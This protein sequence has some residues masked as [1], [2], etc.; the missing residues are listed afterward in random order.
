VLEEHSGGSCQIGRPSCGSSFSSSCNEESEMPRPD[1]LGNGTR[2]CK[3]R[4]RSFEVVSARDRDGDRSL[5]VMISKSLT[6]SSASRSRPASLLLAV[7]P[8][9]ADQ[10]AAVGDHGFELGGHQLPKSHG[11]RWDPARTAACARGSSTSLT[12]G[13]RRGGPSS[14]AR[15]TADVDARRLGALRPLLR[16]SDHC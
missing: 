2:C 13:R 1:G 15:S 16:Y 4:S 12:G 11:Y 14:G 8:H 6:S 5:R 7:P 3:A 9:L 10:G